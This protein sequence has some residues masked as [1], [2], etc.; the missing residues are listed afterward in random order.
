M[1]SKAI[2]FEE[3]GICSTYLII[4]EDLFLQRR[5]N[6]A[7]D[8]FF[9][10]AYFSLAHKSIEFNPE[11][12]K[13]KKK[14]IFCGFDKGKNSFPTVLIAQLSKFIDEASASKFESTIKMTDILEQAL[15]I[16]TKASELLY[17]RQY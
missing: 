3:L 2:A 13:N 14:K 11:I 10:E 7:S 5:T 4:N 15:G 16:I 6:N 17:S 8:C 1:R 9:V 12:S